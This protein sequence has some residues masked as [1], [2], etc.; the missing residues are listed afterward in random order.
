MLN[1]LVSKW[2]ISWYNIGLN[3]KSIIY[4]VKHKWKKFNAENTFS[5]IL[6]PWWFTEKKF[7]NNTRNTAN[8]KNMIYQVLCS[9]IEKFDSLRP[10]S[11]ILLA[12][13]IQLFKKKKF[14]IRLHQCVKIGEKYSSGYSMPTSNTPFK[15]CWFLRFLQRVRKLVTH[16]PWVYQKISHFL[17]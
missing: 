9:K 13:L 11:Q 15:F 4:I 12:S 3:K 8:I 10:F 17:W 7:W 6:T 5:S 16:F 2:R 14:Q 1:L